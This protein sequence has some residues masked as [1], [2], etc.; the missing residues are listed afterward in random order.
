MKKYIGLITILFSAQ[1]ALAQIQ[2]GV[3]IDVF[4]TQLNGVDRTYFVGYGHSVPG[5]TQNDRIGWGATYLA[6]FPISKKFNLETGI[7]IA[8]FRSQFHFEYTHHG[9]HYLIQY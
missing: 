3:G 5:F 9:K 4:Q 1:I 6:V 7:G 2:Y 8:H